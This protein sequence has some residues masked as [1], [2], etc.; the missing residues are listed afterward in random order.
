M[1][2]TEFDKF[3]AEY[4]ALHRK[5]VA[6]SGRTPEF[7]ARYKIEAVRDFVEAT[8]VPHFPNCRV[9]DFGTGV[10]NSIPF[11]SACFPGAELWACDVSRKS[12]EIARTRFPDMARYVL[13]DDKRHQ[14]PP[15][16]LVFTACVFHHIPRAEHADVI[17]SVFGM[18]RQRGLFFIFEHNPLN[19][20]T[21]RAVDACPFDANAVLLPA[22]YT[23]KLLRGAGFREV[24]LSY[25]LFFP[26]FLSILDR[27][28]SH[29][30]WLPLGAQYLVVGRK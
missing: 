20:L 9:L 1:N 19:P 21:R 12:L 24:Q 23:V 6:L 7:F 5:N 15:F 17:N 10:G 25:R 27:L 30:S 22:S 29:L 28:E 8:S 3:A 4:D 26:G 2:E 16:D 14:L 18:I 13:L 11:L